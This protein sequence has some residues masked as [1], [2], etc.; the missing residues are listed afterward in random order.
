[1]EK[2]HA[3]E[4]LEMLRVGQNLILSNKD[5]CHCIVKLKGFLAWLEGKGKYQYQRAGEFLPK[6]ASENIV[7]Y[8]KTENELREFL[9]DKVERDDF[10]GLVEGYI[11]GKSGV[12]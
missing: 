2:I 7:K 10:K 12:K 4:I 1:M 9:I 3:D 5:G 6:G 11:G 8:F